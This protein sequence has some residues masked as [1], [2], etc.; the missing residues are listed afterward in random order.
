MYQKRSLILK[1]AEWGLDV[2]LEKLLA[3]IPWDSLEED[4]WPVRCTNITF[5]AFEY[6]PQCVS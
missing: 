3:F 5:N 1:G 6:C 2:P 4:L